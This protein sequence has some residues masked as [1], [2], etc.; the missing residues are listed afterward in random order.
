MLQNS[1][2]E[3]FAVEKT[4]VGGEQDFVV[5]YGFLEV[6]GKI[7]W[8]ACGAFVVKTWWTPCKMWT[9]NSTKMVW[10]KGTLLASIFLD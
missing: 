1:G 3:F 10:E 2:G 6:F 4:R 7:V 9:K 5:G 8:F